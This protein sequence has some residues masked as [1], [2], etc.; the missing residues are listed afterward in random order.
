MRN[1][2]EAALLLR[3]RRNSPLERTVCVGTAAGIQ[4]ETMQHDDMISVLP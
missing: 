3:R 2:L 4:S 1:F